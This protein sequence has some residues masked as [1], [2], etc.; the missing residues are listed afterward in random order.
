VSFLVPGLAIA[1]LGAAALPIILH[2][3]LRRPRATAWPSTM[4]L[5]RALERLRRRRRLDGWVLLVLRTLGIGLVG[6]AMAGPFIGLMGVGSGPRELWI[7][8]DDGATSAE[9]LPDGTPVIQVMQDHL[10]REVSTLR[11]GDRAAIV[12]AARP[13]RVE[14]QPTLDHERIRSSIRDWIA[15]PVPSDLLGALELALPPEQESAPREVLLASGLRRGSVDADRGLPA[16]WHDRARAVR[17]RCVPA[18]PTPAPNRWIER[19]SIVRASSVMEQGSMRIDIRRSGDTGSGDDVQVRS[20][21]GDILAQSDIAWT[22]GTPEAR[23]DIPLPRTPIESCTIGLRPDAQPLDDTLSVVNVATITPKVTIVG[24]RREDEG[25]DRLSASGWI[26]Q[27]MESADVQV[28]EL[29]PTM[30]GIRPPADADVIILTRPDLLDAGGWKWTSR[31]LR[32]GGLIVIT[33]VQGADDAWILDLNRE[34]GVRVE[35]SPRNDGEIRRFAPRQPR[36]DLLAALGAEIDVLTE[37]VS[38]QRSWN[39]ASD[40][41]DSVLMFESG[42]PAA[43]TVRPLDGQGLLLLLAFPPELECTDMPLR[44]LM[45]PFF[46]EVIRAGRALARGSSVIMTGTIAQ[47]GPSAAGGVLRSVDPRQTRVI[48]IDSEGRTT[49]PVPFPGVWSLEQRDGRARPIAARLDPQ[50]ASIEHVDASRIEAWW[51]PVGVWTRL[52]AERTVA[53]DSVRQ[54]ST[55]TLPLLLLALLFL[56]GE[57]LWSRRSS[58]RPMVETAG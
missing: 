35:M 46:Q 50:A 38:V 43:L 2:V 33:P 18:L 47:L 48:E 12:R 52:S 54:E 5:Q 22:A 27:A 15:R 13:P 39:I 20:A 44:P 32:D 19:A 36:G 9:T 14:L 40:R 17:W 24:R 53:Q 11:P 29:D 55:W 7:V 25:L 45:V 49:Q 34:S 51:S 1:A 23:R 56:V 4:L 41:S 37:P 57:S 3:L 58:P 30:L 16:S 6:F 28:R 42:E 21:V 10:L 31:H 8:I 26:R